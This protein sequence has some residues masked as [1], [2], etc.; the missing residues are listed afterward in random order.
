MKEDILTL[1]ETV[2]WVLSS[3][4]RS[5]EDDKW[6]IIRVLQERGITALRQL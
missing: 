5:R 2:E 4:P 1:S 6:L 3:D